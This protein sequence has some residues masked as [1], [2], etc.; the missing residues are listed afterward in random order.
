MR[1]LLKQLVILV[2]QA[3]I[4]ILLVAIGPCA[5]S[6]VIHMISFIV[7]R[8]PLHL[9][10][11]KSVQESPGRSLDLDDPFKESKLP[12]L[13]ELISLIEPLMRG[14]STLGTLVEPP[15]KG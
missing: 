9:I 6:R 7:H 14:Q 1:L 13:G 5:F 4:L 8:R 11:L 12:L 15:P 10:N 2:L 3:L